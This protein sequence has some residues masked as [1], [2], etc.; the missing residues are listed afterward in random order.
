VTELREEDKAIIMNNHHLVEEVFYEMRKTVAQ[1]Y[2]VIEVLVGEDWCDDI[3]D[4]RRVPEHILGFWRMEY[5]DDLNYVSVKEAIKDFNWV[6]CEKV[7]VT[8]HKW[9]ILK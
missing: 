9:K 3:V 7:S 1:S 6:R 2:Y 5:A 8:T 4:F